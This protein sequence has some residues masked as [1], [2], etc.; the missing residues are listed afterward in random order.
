MD[1]GSFPEDQRVPITALIDIWKEL[2]GVKEDDAILNLIDLRD[3]NLAD[4]VIT[5]YVWF[6]S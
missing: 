1:L 5:R 6:L 4:L 2:Y 3:Q